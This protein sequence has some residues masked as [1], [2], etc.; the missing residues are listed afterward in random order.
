MARRRLFQFPVPWVTDENVHRVITGGATFGQKSDRFHR[1][2][3]I[4]ENAGEAIYS[5]AAGTVYDFG[6][7]DEAGNFVI[8]Q[9]DEASYSYYLHMVNRSNY[10][11]GQTVGLNDVIGY[12]GS[13]GWATG[14]HIH[15]A[16]SGV[17]NWTGWVDPVQYVLDRYWYDDGQPEAG[18]HL[19]AA[20]QTELAG[21]IG[22]TY[23][24]RQYWSDVQAISRDRGWYTG[25][26]DGIP[27]PLTFDA[28][29]AL[30][31]DVFD[32]PPVV[33]PPVDED[34]I[35]KPIPGEP[36]T[37]VT[38]AIPDVPK[39]DPVKP[40]TIEIPVRPV[41]DPADIK[42]ITDAALAAMPTAQLD[43]VEYR[44][45]IPDGVR[46][47]AYLV[48]GLGIPAVTAAFGLAALAAQI[49]GI[50]AMSAA[51][52]INGA[53]GAWA[54]VCGVSNFTRTKG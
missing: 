15:F 25:S 51:A 5:I 27:G 49:D 47:S 3:D 38:P 4:G 19:T 46:L 30:W 12:V 9:H 50:L 33:V 43:A 7:D 52:I 40:P 34:P 44:P 26:I 8:I 29:Q 53:L 2:A 48:A 6:Y 11:V 28:E 35:F 37:P 36:V 54:A 45:A 21:W 14:A 22:Q 41:L 16:V 24:A 32:K 18:S 31:A 23:G 17:P 39:E 10:D 20:Q 13:T 42:A 1:G